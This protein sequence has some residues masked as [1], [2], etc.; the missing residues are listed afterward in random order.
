[1][2]LITKFTASSNTKFLLHSLVLLF[3]LYE[4]LLKM[5]EG[6]LSQM[7]SWLTL[8]PSGQI[9]CYLIPL[10]LVLGLGIGLMGSMITVRKHLQV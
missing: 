1:M 8:M 3:L 4:L 7:A 2:P 9:F 10:C 6:E 5:A